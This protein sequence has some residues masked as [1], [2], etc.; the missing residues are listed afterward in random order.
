MKLW[1][2][3]DPFGIPRIGARSAG[4]RT[5]R[6]FRVFP[7]R[8][9]GYEHRNLIEGRHPLKEELDQVATDRE[10]YLM[11][12]SGHGGIINFTFDKH[13]IDASTENPAG[14]EF[15]LR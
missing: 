7:I 15:F 1:A 3:E 14:G 10:V 4:R 8:G 9:Y 13:G 5:H 12:A 11:N 6:T 2:G